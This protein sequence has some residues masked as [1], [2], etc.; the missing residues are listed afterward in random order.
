MYIALLLTLIVLMSIF[1]T[2][3]SGANNQ[4]TSSVTFTSYRDIP[5]VTEEEINAIEALK[6]QREHFVY[7]VLPSTETFIDPSGNMNGW[8]VLFCDWLSELFGIPF[9]AEFVAYEDFLAKMA[10][11]EADFN[12]L[13][14]ATPERL[15]SFFMTSAIIQQTIRTF[16]LIGSTSL[17]EIAE[18]R[19]P[20]YGFIAGSSTIGEVASNTTPGSFETILVANTDQAHEMLHS[21]EIDVFINV[22]TAEAAFDKF[23]DVETRDFFPLMF[24]PVSLTTQN[25]ELEPIISIV[26]KALDN[27]IA[28]YLVN[29]YNVGYHEY[30]K[31]KLH[32]QL[33]DEERIYIQNNPV[34]PVAAIYSNYPICFFNTRENEWQGVFFDLIDQIEGI[35]DL[36]F[37][38][39]NDQHTEWSAMQE[40]LR[41][42]EVKFVAD[43]IWTKAREEFFIWSNVSIQNDYYALISRS[44]HRNITLNE[45]PHISVGVVRDTAYTAMFM[46]WFPN[47]EHITYYA[48][49]EESFIALGNGEVDMVMTTERRLMFLTHYQELTGFKLNYVFDQGISTRFGFNQNEAVLRDII[50]K[51]LNAIDTKGIANQWMRNT[52]DYRAKVA[53]AQQPLLIGSSVLLIC[54]LVLIIVL[55]VRSRRVGKRLEVLVNERTYE[56]AV[57]SNAK[58]AFLANMSHEIRTPLNSIVGFSELALDNEIPP[59]TKGYLTNILDNSEGLLQIIN[60]ILDISKIE[61]GKMELENVPFDPRDLFTT[62]RTLILPKVLDKGLKLSF[63]VEPT[64]GKMPLGDPLRLRQVLAN[65]LSNAVKFTEEGAIRLWAVVKEQSDNTVVI[66]VEVQDSG[67]GMTPEQ[68][69]GIFDPFIQAESGTTRKYGGTGLGL[70]ITKNIIE[71]MGSELIVESIPG[72]GSKFGFE[73]TLETVDITNDEFQK[74][75]VVHEDIKKPT[76]EGLVLVCEDNAMNQQVISEHLER[77]GLKC[78]IAENGQIG[79]AMVRERAKKDSTDKQFDLIFMDIHMPVMDGIEASEKILELGVDVPIVAMTANIMTHDRELYKSSGMDDHVGKPFTSQELWRCLLNYFKP[80][81]WEMESGEKQSQQIDEL[82]QKLINKFVNNNRDK[83]SEIN[84]ALRSGDVMLAHRLVHTLKSNAGQLD[85]TFLQTICDEIEDG[86]KDGENRTTE[87]QMAA[88][89]NELAITLKEFEPLVD[90]TISE[91]SENDLLD[92]AAALKVL[93]DLEL[94]INDKDMEC[95]SM[96]NVLQGVRGSSELIKQME[97]FDFENAVKT[98]EEL[99]K[100]FTQPE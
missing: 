31:T 35:T 90:E 67:I 3:C 74:R 46:Q 44:D 79:V 59:K 98:L 48:G 1:L 28:S 92:D 53:E 12:G 76:F 96:V 43:L 24:S 82:K 58:S 66:H 93:N 37:D 30:L 81:D 47:H 68:I 55:F 56:L 15:E 5:G 52:F 23:G 4:T 60:D 20:R 6:L 85:K 65:L 11:L 14:T 61:S 86:L 33:T 19:L 83:Y 27:G 72:I 63:Y 22:N 95:L 26:Q 38:L 10:S 80:V 7:A 25:P 57:A 16:R 39:R 100:T 9:N 62:C 42:G 70:S 87:E 21:G 34:I 8:S 54:V 78:V 51:A 17:E 89:K 73:L 99:K 75:K 13:M 18:T 71:M 77:V 32:N 69:E 91:S 40:M 2:G 97:D 45:I 50:D 41:N 36:T 49:I 88:F 29:L 84:E 64:V 94:L